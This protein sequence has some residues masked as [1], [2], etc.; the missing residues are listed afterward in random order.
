[1]RHFAAFALLAVAGSLPV[2]RRRRGATKIL[3]QRTPDGSI[4]LTDQPSPG[5]KTERSLAG[6]RPGSGRRAAARDRRQGGGQSRQRAH[7]AL[8][9]QPAARRRRSATHAPGLPPARARPRRRRRRA[10]RHQ[11]RLRRRRTAG[12]RRSARRATPAL[13]SATPA[14]WIPPARAARAGAAAA[15]AASLED[16][17]RPEVVDVGE[18]R[19]GDEQVAEA[20]EERVGVVA[21]EV[22][23]AARAPSRRARSRVSGVTKA[24]ALALDAVDAVGVGGEHPDV[25]LALQRR[26]RSRA[27]TRSA[28]PPRP[29]LCFT[30]TVVSPPES[31]TH[32]RANGW[33]RRATWRASAAC[34]LPTSRDSPSISSP[35]MCASMPGRARQRRGRVER[36]LRRR[37][38]VDLVAGEHRIARLGRLERAALEAGADRARGTAIA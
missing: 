15:H 36:L 23:A 12:R 27:G 10:G 1:M 31:T 6:Q 2:A 28:R 37:D 30:V 5:A 21:V 29:P 26:A 8:D 9:R 22:I 20:G 3:Q 4:L 16:Q 11:L 24:P 38:E 7:P 13:A 32:G 14:S 35:R 17:D 34:T 25:G 33:P 19:A 18:R